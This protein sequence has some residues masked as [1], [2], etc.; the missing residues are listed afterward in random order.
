MLTLAVLETPLDS[1]I[2]LYV[3]Y[4]L[5]SVGTI[6]FVGFA[7][8]SFAGGDGD[9][10]VDAG[11][12]S[13]FH[14][15]T[16]H[17]DTGNAFLKFFS[18][19]AFTAFMMFFGWSGVFFGDTAAGLLGSLAF[20][21]FM[22]FITGYL[23]KV[24]LKLQESGNISPTSY[25]GCRGTVYMNIPESGSGYGKVSVTTSCGVRELNAVS[26]SS[27]IATGTLVSVVKMADSAMYV[28][29]RVVTD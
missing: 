29:E 17:A 23:L 5:A 24:L 3:Y 27:A 13:D 10:D 26:E 9:T 6:F 1:D 22:M 19:K 14:Q 25:I 28:V 18:L 8:L 7:V 15:G 16:D 20:G 21:L 12:D 2:L 11:A 4:A